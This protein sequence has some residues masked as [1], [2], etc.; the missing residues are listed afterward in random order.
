MGDAT[1]TSTPP[2][3]GPSSYG[4]DSSAEN[5]ENDL[6]IP[7]N[8][9]DNKKKK[10]KKKMVLKRFSEMADKL[11]EN[12]EVSDE[13]IDAFLAEFGDE[14]EDGT[15]DNCIDD[16]FCNDVEDLD[17]A[18]SRSKSELRQKHK[19]AKK[20]IKDWIKKHGKL[21]WVK[22]Q[23]EAKKARNKP[24]AK[25]LKKLAAKKHGKSSAGK[26]AARIAKSRDS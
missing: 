23:K 8:K 24:A 16:M 19:G 2:E 14:N 15:F 21:A 11:L 12:E 18:V 5:L 7:A 17:E 26:E 20:K 1:S 10:R 6:Y 3:T 9:L 13:E 22:K 4:S 25:R